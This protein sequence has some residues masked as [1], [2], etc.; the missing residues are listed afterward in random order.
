LATLT[1]NTVRL[2][3]KRAETLFAAPTKLQLRAFH[4]LGVSLTA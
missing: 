1:R 2:A 3:A 4:L